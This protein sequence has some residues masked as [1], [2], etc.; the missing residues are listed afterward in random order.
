V[1]EDRVPA[2]VVEALRR[3]VD[4]RHR[5]LFGAAYARRERLVVGW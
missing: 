4:P 1:I 3:R 5:I 2:D